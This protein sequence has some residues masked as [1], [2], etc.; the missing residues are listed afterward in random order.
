MSFLASQ[1]IAGPEAANGSEH[2]V[3]KPFALLE[4]AFFVSKFGKEIA[5]QS[6]HGCIPLGG[7][8]ASLSVDVIRQ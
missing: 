8:Y 4:V 3:L 7:F 6:A 1:S 5:N 2:L